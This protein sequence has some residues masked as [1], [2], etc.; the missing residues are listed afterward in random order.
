MKTLTRLLPV[1]HCL[2]PA[3]FAQH[4]KAQ[5]YDPWV[6]KIVKISVPFLKGADYDR[7]EN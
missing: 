4:A 2:A 1:L 6:E 7:I 3:A 5:P